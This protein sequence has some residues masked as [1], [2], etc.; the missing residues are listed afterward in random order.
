MPSA[1]VF[2]CGRITIPLELRKSMNLK[3]G[4]KIQFMKIDKTFYRID[5]ERNSDV[6][7][8]LPLKNAETGS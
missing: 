2:S 8:E 1:R 4:D 6:E 5:V 7:L 3:P